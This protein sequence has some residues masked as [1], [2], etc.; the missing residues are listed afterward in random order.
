MAFP[1]MTFLCTVQ[2]S[3]TNAYLVIISPN[4]YQK[5]CQLNHMESIRRILILLSEIFLQE[6][7][8]FSSLLAGGINIS[9]VHLDTSGKIH[10]CKWIAAIESSNS[11]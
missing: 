11:S 1:Y 8:S 9:S 10:D 5:L 7:K 3:L 4:G 6:T 2:F